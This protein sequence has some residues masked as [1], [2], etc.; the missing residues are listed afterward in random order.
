MIR[1]VFRHP[2]LDKVQPVRGTV[3]NPVVI[4]F[5]G[6]TCGKMSGM[7]EPRAREIL[8]D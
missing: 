1:V 5:L 6:K 3:F 8:I 7:K 2:N 4:L